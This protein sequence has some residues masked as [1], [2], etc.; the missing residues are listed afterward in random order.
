[1]IVI[2]SLISLAVASIIGIVLAAMYNKGKFST[3]GTIA[4]GI[5]GALGLLLLII[6]AF[7]QSL[8]RLGISSLVIFILVAIGGFALLGFDLSKKPLPKPLIAVH[9][10]AAVIAFLILLF[11]AVQ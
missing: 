6:A 1:M 8:S 3:T 4:H 10:A 7:N 9:G 5:F 2:F 11:G